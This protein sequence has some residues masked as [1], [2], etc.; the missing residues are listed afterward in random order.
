[1]RC[2]CGDENVV[3]NYVGTVHS[4]YQETVYREGESVIC[5]VVKCIKE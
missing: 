4:V 5:P 3:K 1:M 2:A